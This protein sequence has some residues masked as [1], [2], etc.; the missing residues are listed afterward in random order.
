M[1]QV[2]H[3]LIYRSD[4]RLATV[5]RPM[6]LDRI[7]I[8]F[9]ELTIIGIHLGYPWTEE[10]ISVATKH[11]NVYMAAT[12]MRRNIGARRRCTSP[13]PTGRTNSCSVPTGG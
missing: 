8:D 5:A 11:P 1:M 2:G 6:A 4:N 13:T 10:M 3:C 7:A 9:P 12:P